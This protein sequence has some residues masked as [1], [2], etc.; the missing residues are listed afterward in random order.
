[1]LTVSGAHDFLVERGVIPDY[2]V[3]CDPREH[4]T[5]MLQKLHKDVKY[6]MAT[7]CHP[8]LWERLKD[9]DVQVWHLHNDPA[10]SVWLKENDPHGTVVG[11]GSTVG[12]RALEI[13]SLLGFRRFEIHGMDCSFESDEVHHAGSHIG[14]KQNVVEVSVDGTWFKSSPQMIEA[15][16]EMIAFVQNYDAD[17]TFCGRGLQQA[18]V[19]HFLKRFKVVD[20]N[21]PEERAA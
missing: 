15:A 20:F 18:M 11:G 6:R 8:S 5:N 10:T 1:M 14:K 2:H 9:Y 12:M 16:K 4:K 7:V 21:Q 13:A 19:A 17:I 3:D